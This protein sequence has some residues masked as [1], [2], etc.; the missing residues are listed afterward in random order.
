MIFIK[1]IRAGAL[2]YVIVVAVVVAILVFAFISLV[3]LYQR[4]T[5]KYAFS[6]E[7]IYNTQLGFDYLQYKGI[8]SYETIEELSILED[9]EHSKLTVLKKNWGI[10]DIVLVNSEV[11]KQQF[12][13]IGL[14]GYQNSK[15]NALFLK[16]NNQ[17]LVMVGNAQLLGNV[18]LPKMGVKTGN[19]SGV[20]FYGSQLVIGN[21]EL[22]TTKLPKIENIDYLKSLS[23][24][25]YLEN[26]IFFNLGDGVEKCQSFA[27]PTMITQSET[28]LILNNISLK[29]NIIITSK[30]KIIIKPSTRLNDIILIAP[31]IIIE[32]NTK[33][34]FQALASKTIQVAP[35]CKLNYPSALVLLD[36]KNSSVLINDLNSNKEKEHKIEIE[37]FSSVKGVVV[38]YSTDSERQYNTQINIQ[39]KATVTGEVYCTGNLELQG[40]VNG[41]VFTNQFLIKKSGGTYV[42]H[43]FN[44]KINSE[45]LPKQYAGLQIQNNANA[46]AKWMY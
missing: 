22:S 45:N 41:S 34:N 36:D 23:Q 37:Q 35:N 10:F 6:K 15:R 14:L 5:D 13:K 40:N 25:P 33:G 31:E 19:I 16:D 21:Q 3:Y 29:G 1:K 12:Q 24:N 20:S 46:V 7:A 43:L 39:E 27:Q 2:Q 38:Y 9:N 42:N 18:A 32:S 8:S 4:S 28:D 17:A 30:T 26:T 44:G 11:H